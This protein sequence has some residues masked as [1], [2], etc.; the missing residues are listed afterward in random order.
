M[1]SKSKKNRHLQTPGTPPRPHNVANIV[2]DA[3]GKM[4]GIQLDDGRRLDGVEAGKMQLAPDGKTVMLSIVVA[5]PFL[6]C[7]RPAIEA[8]H[9]AHES[10]PRVQPVQRPAGIVG[11]DGRPLS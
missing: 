1:S 6:V 8:F 10:R 11:P 5:G 2:L 3:D 4:T 7:G 9:R